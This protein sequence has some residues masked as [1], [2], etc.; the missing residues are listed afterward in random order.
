M[1]NKNWAHEHARGE[2]ILTPAEQ[3]AQIIH[4]LDGNIRHTYGN[5]QTRL[6]DLETA[7]DKAVDRLI[8]GEIFNLAELDQARIEYA[9]LTKDME[10]FIDVVLRYN[11]HVN[12]RRAD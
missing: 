9:G 1:T 10:I 3:D 12:T 7:L 5:I 4:R 6:S 11:N 2:Q 8:E